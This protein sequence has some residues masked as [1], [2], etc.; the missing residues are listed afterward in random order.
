MSGTGK[1]N[2]AASKLSRNC[3]K[4]VLSGSERIGFE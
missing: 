2:E 4:G 1:V 3:K